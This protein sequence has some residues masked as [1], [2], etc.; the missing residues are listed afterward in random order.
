MVMALNGITILR[1][2]QRYKEHLNQT[3][4]SQSQRCGEHMETTL[5]QFSSDISKELNMYTSEIFSDPA[6]F[7]EASRSLRLFYTKYRDLITRI[8]IYDNHKN[9]YALFLESEDNFGKKDAFVVDS[10]AMR[11]Q[12]SLSPLDLVEQDGPVLEY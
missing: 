8:S 6:K 12:K 4:F 2:N 3:L 11:R 5:L 9:F 1:V 7:E 10:F